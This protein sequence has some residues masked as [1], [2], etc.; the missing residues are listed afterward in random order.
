MAAISLGVAVTDWEAGAYPANMSDP[1][2]YLAI[3]QYIYQLGPSDSE[4]PW[5]TECGGQA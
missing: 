2:H 4:Q 1:G 3:D 5:V